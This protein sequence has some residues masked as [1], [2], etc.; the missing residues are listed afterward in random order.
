MMAA[1]PIFAFLAD[2]IGGFPNEQLHAVAAFLLIL[3]LGVVMGIGVAGF[4]LVMYS[5]RKGR[6]SD[7]GGLLGVEAL[8]RDRRSASA[9]LGLPNRWLAIRSGN[10]YVVQA[11]LG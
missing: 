4:I 5:L 10:P 7:R 11:A 6:M 9:L 2:A 1:A 3:L 8:G